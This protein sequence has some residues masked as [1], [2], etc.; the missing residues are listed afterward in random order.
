MTFAVDWAFCIKEQRTEHA[1][2]SRDIDYW[3]TACN[4]VVVVEVL[5]SVLRCQLT[6]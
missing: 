4:V 2:A 3:L 1:G 6:Y 5:L